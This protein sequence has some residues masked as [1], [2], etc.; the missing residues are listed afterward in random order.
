MSTV[1]IL[2][3]ATCKSD[4][5]VQPEAAITTAPQELEL[6]TTASISVSR[7]PLELPGFVLHTHGA[8]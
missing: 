6:V 7:E 2:A 5:Q 8:F 4:F 1:Y 3:V